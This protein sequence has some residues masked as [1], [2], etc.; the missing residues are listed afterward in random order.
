LAEV[1]VCFEALW[2]VSFVIV[3][4]TCDERPEIRSRRRSLTTLRASG[5]CDL[6]WPGV[7]SFRVLRRLES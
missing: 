3:I 6:T 5:P 7:S 1:G 2:D 4:V